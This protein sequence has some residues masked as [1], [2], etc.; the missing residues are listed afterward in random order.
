MKTFLCKK[1]P[2][3]SCKFDKDQRARNVLDYW[4][5]KARENNVRFTA[6]DCNTRLVPVKIKQGRNMIEIP[7]EACVLLPGQ[8]PKVNNFSPH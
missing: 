4:A 3:A 6:R 7:A 1:L 5:N 2:K 8:K